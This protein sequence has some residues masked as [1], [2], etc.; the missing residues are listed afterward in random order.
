MLPNLKLYAALGVAIVIAL[1]SVAV[2]VQTERL[3]AV[4]AEYGAFVAQTKAIGEAAEAKRQQDIK[5]RA[6][7]S[8][9]QESDHVVRYSSLDAKYRAALAVA[10][11]V[12]NANSGSSQA[13]PLSDAA[14]VI[15]CPDRQA[16][17]AGRLERLEV[18]V[19]ALL[20]RG[21]KAIERTVTCKDWIDQ[22]TAVR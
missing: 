4:K 9:K 22:Q 7:I 2:Y 17:T 21:N 13:K 6:A 5:D 14:A 1:L 20:D 10:R 19:L 16:D 18:G 3:R 12:P 11:R 8:A 15:S